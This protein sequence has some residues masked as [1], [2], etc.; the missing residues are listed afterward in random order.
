MKWLSVALILAIG[1]CADPK[2]V[3]EG[4][5]VPV[6]SKLQQSGDYHFV[7]ADLYVSY[8]WEQVASESRPGVLIVR[9]FRPDP[10]DGFPFIADTDSTLTAKISMPGMGH[11]AP[12]VI[13]EKISAGTYRISKM[14]FSIMHGQ[15]EIKLQL[16]SA[17]GNIEDVVVPYT[18]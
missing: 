17:D 4:A 18:F 10:L 11:G 3:S 15:W 8:D 13:V 5:P 7:Q 12:P 16:H 1:G 2:Y 9:L 14:Y 6:D